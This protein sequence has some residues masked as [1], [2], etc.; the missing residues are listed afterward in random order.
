M[1]DS[2]VATT[3]GGTPVV[4]LDPSQR[5][6]MGRAARAAVPRS[7]HGEWA[8]GPD[9]ADPTSLLTA[10]ETTRVPDLVP[11]RHERML[12]SPFTFYRGA[13]VIMAA[14]LAVSPTAGCGCRRAAMPT[15]R[16]SV[17]S[18]RRTGRWSSTSTT[19]TRPVPGRSSGTSSASPRASRSRGA[20]VPSRPR[21][22]A[23]WSPGSRSRTGRRWPSSPP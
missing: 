13:A 22:S 12:A 11:L 14:D 1:S 3:D 10:Q 18:R 21:R 6:R 19:S 23:A 7:S 16:T 17:V 9:R 15:C 2:G 8:P 4:H 20:P 5:A